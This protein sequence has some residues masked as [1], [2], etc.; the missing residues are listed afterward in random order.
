ME[1]RVS[2]DFLVS[3]NSE[4]RIN[5]IDNFNV[6]VTLAPHNGGHVINLVM[7][8]RVTIEQ[9]TLSDIIFQLSELVDDQLRKSSKK[10]IKELNKKTTLVFQQLL[11]LKIAWFEDEQEAD[12]SANNNQTVYLN[13]DFELEIKEIYG[14]E[15]N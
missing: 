11:L 9:S 10:I 8:E 7:S 4:E 6:K 15:S 2:S 1:D 5:R 12:F 13:D 14:G 3:G